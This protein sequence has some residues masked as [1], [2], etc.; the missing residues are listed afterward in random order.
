MTDLNLGQP[1]FNVGMR[2]ALLE[3]VPNLAVVSPASGFEGFAASAGRIVEHNAGV[4]QGLGI[5]A[6][7]ALLGDRDLADISNIEVRH[8]L[9][10]TGQR[11]M[12]F[13]MTDPI[14]VAKID[15]L[16]TALVI[17]EA[18]TLMGDA[19]E[20][21]Y[22]PVNFEA[23]ADGTIGKGLSYDPELAEGE[24][25]VTV[26]LTD[27]VTNLGADAV[28][29]NLVGFYQITDQKGG[30]DTDRDGMADE[31]LTPGLDNF[32]ASAYARAAILN[33]MDNL[34]IRAGSSGN[35]AQNTTVDELSNVIL[36]E[37]ELFAPFVIANGGTI[38]FD[39]FVT[40]E[41]GESDGVFNDA[42]DFLQDQVAYFSFIEANPDG[43]AHLKS[44][45]NNI[46][47]F[48]DLPAN[49]L[50]AVSDN[51]FNDAV[52]RGTGSLRGDTELKALLYKVFTGLAS[53]TRKYRLCKGL[54][55]FITR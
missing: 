31:G 11:P 19:E 52:F 39:G 43:V 20:L 33:H 13:G 1:L 6:I 3:D 21:N 32:D 45:G 12:I 2:H 18:D 29:D 53:K 48:E 51:D 46:F 17:R 15:S 7:I 25:Q 49:L 42:A 9:D 8:V 50:G 38:G 37:D 5:A 4:G 34:E 36:A 35:P 10:Q 54:R 26:N 27:D 55:C 47:G 16:E 22:I 40:A 41:D 14:E 24:K 23:E 30:I 44:F 28:F